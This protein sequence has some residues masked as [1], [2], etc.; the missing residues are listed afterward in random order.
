ME[1]SGAGIHEAG[2]G[3]AGLEGGFSFAGREMRR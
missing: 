3:R 2:E 1:G